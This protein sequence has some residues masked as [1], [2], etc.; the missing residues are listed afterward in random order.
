MQGALDDVAFQDAV[1]EVSHGVGTIGLRGVE[2]TIDVVDG[3]ALVPHLEAPDAAGRQI[4]RCA[5]GN[6]LFG[7]VR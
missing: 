5:D 3:D 7:H 1:A 2:R 6:G 4:G